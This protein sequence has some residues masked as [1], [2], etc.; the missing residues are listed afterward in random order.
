MS[1]LKTWDSGAWDAG[2]WDATVIQSINK[3]NAK[4]ALNLVNLKPR[5]KLAKFQKAVTKCGEVPILPNPTPS[6]ADCTASND[7]LKNILDQIDLAEQNLTNM[8]ITRDQLLVVAT[9]NYTSLGSCVESNSQ[10]D[11]AFITAKGY[12]VAGTPSPTPMVSQPMNLVLTHGDHDGAT[13]ASW[14]RDKSARSTEVHT[15]PDPMTDNSWVLDQIATKSSCT[16][17]NK[18]IGSKMWVRVRSIG[19]DGPGLWSEPAFIIVT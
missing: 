14:N 1:K 5:E 9:N 11:P 10:G 3:M 12:D 4:V 8:R 13:D 2:C 17:Q 16:I 15:S 6:L 7:A 19:K 18:T